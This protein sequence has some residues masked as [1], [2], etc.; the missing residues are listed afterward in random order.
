MERYETAFYAPLHSNWDN[1][2][3]WVER[4]KV[5]AYARANTIWKKMLSEY[6]QPPL[7]E[8]IN[9]A[10]LDYMGKRKRDF[11]KTA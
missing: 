3:T 11:Y 8:A 10:L 2:D 7:D 9:E 1:H 4:G 5:D 6:E